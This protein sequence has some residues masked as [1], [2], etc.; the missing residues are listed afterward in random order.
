MPKPELHF[1][2]A[3][4]AITGLSLL[5]AGSFA[6]DREPV[7]VNS[8]EAAQVIAGHLAVEKLEA[9][10][11]ET[12]TLSAK[13]EQLLIDQE[14][15]E[16]QETTAQ[17]Y[18]TKPASFYWEI[19]EPYQEVTVTNGE[20][21]WRFEPDLDQVTIQLFNDELER[22]PVM[23]LNGSAES[24][25]A[26]YDVE[27]VQMDDGKLSRFI[28]YPRHPGSLFERLSLTFDGLDLS[29]MQW[30]TSLGQKTSLNFHAV[31]R[32]QAMATGQ[33]SFTPPSGVE[34]IDNRLD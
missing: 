22:T 10:L 26:A 12:T 2:R 17:L 7:Q 16:L 19:L 4:A 27:S 20:V 13:V 1:L 25:A 6:Q 11:K 30:E 29:E 8:Q 28:L 34:I 33:F 5:T 18:M 3:L 24:I 31:L 32:N 15:R 21:I 23:L 9:I 14:G